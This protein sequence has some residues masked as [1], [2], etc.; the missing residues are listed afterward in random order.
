MEVVKGRGYVYS[1]Q[2][3][4]VWCVK[5]RRNILNGQVSTRLKELLIQISKDNGFQILE[6]NMNE[7]HIHML[8]NCTPQHYI[9]NI[10]KAM[11]GVSARLL[12]KEFGDDLRSKL[13][14]WTSMESF[15]FCSYSF[16][17]YRRT[18]YRVYKKSKKKIA[19]Q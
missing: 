19:N 12:M 15:L 10:I 11:K 13:W 2:Y 17:K 6:M 14:G 5:Y 9:P 7:D 18:D 3:H 8:I 4:I 1:I 16:W